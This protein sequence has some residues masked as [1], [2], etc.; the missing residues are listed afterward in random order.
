MTASTAVPIRI[1]VL[2]TWDEV[3]LEAEPTRTMAELKAMAL[4]RAGVATAPEKYLV[5]YLGAERAD[6]ESLAD[7]GVLANGALIVLRRHRIPVR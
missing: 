4:A 7:A 5:K 1:T 6:G 3:R 2:E